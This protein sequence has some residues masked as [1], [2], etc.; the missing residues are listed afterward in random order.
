MPK[1]T[2][3]FIKKEVYEIEADNS[4][5]AKELAEE[6]LLNDEWA[7]LDNIVDKIEVEEV[8]EDVDFQKRI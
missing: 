8:E 5:E 2:V 1:Y 4:Y 7:F 6:M 3:T